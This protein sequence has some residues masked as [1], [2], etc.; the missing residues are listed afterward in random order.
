MMQRVIQRRALRTSY[1]QLKA[2]NARDHIEQ[3][4]LPTFHFQ[5][6]LPR[7]PIPEL[8]STCEK[9]LTSL[10]ALEGHPDI[11]HEDIERARQQ[12]NAFLAANGPEIDQMI[13]TQDAKNDH[14]SF[15]YDAWSEMYLSDRRPL[16]VNYNPILTWKE[17]PNEDLNTQP[18]RAAQICWAAAK[19]YL[20]L[21]D[22]HL[23][24]QVFHMK[25]EPS[26]NAQMLTKFLPKK[27]VTLKGQGIDNQAL[28]YLP[29]AANKSYPLDMSQIGNLFFSTRIPSDG[30]DFI[31]KADE[32]AN[33]VIVQS[34]GRF[35][36]LDVLV[37][38][39]DSRTPRD[40]Y[41][42]L[43]D[44][45]SI[46]ADSAK[47]GPV[48]HP[49]STLSSVD[50]DTWT[51]ARKELIRLGNADALAEIDDAMF[52]LSLDDFSAHEPANANVTLDEGEEPAI[53]GQFLWGPAENRWVDKSFSVIVS[54]DGQCGLNFEHAWGDG[55]CVLAFFNKTHEHILEMNPIRPGEGSTDTGF[56][57]TEPNE[58]HF[59]LDDQMKN[60]ISN[61]RQ[62]YA[63]HIDGLVIA[64][65]RS[66]DVT[67]KWLEANKIG[68][69][70]FLQLSLQIAHDQL[71]GWPCATY[72]SASTCAYQ[73]GRT[74]TIRPCTNESR[75]LCS[76]YAEKDF[77]NP[78]FQ[79]ELDTCLREAI[80]AHNKIMMSCLTGEGFDRHL[81]AI[82]DQCKKQGIPM[83]EFL[84]DKTMDVMKHFRMSTSTLNSDHVKSGGFGP[85][86]D[87][88][89]A[90][91]YMV[92]DSYL[93]VV[94]I[95]KPANGV[96]AE[97]FADT[98]NNVWNNMKIC[99][100]GAK[101][102]SK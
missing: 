78:D 47:K 48:E 36:T 27:R 34:K 41:H 71:H 37:G 51:A 97:L 9:Y 13:R 91:G 20:T 3:T 58:V 25:D 23:Q 100:E 16:P 49:V 67:R 28:R 81:F 65:T 18:I 12:V 79:R 33:H 6:A 40:P 76:L 46:L 83:P 56:G 2:F 61:A 39:G 57:F 22:G 69:D 101:L 68:A 45:H 72:E 86:V 5:G 89:Y 32:K 44:I 29:Y 1:S 24:P 102:S 52:C 42:I 60:T 43:S 50:R 38:S 30:K 4:Y 35:Y 54:D 26:K 8:N 53:I 55:A 66:T 93:G 82:A 14:T 75:T 95:S 11:K 62:Y 70:G 96:D 19:Y 7:L 64:Y 98:V 74:E 73:H 94:A 84:T 92:Y 85:V 80:K 15:Y 10:E 99:V 77:E 17:L 87:D 90:L 59:I 63:D 21:V 31:Q 88:G